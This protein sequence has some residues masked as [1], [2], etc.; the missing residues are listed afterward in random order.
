M[1]K[2]DGI[3]WLLFSLGAGGFIVVR[4]RMASRVRRIKAVVSRIR[5]GID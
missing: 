3:F 2:T 1:S 4:A 5:P